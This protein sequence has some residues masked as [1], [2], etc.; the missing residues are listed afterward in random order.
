MAGDLARRRIRASRC[1]TFPSARPDPR[2]PPPRPR[3]APRRRYR[4]RGSDA[5]TVAV[6]DGGQAG[7]VARAVARARAAGADVT[8]LAATGHGAWTPDVSV[9]LQRP[10][11]GAPI[12]AALRGMS[13]RRV[14]VV[15]ETA[16]GRVA[17]PGSA[18][19]AAAGV[20]SVGG[21]DCGVGGP[22][23]RR[24]LAVPGVAAPGRRRGAPRVD[25]GGCRVG[26]GGARTRRPRGPLPRWDGVLVEALALAAP[27]RGRLAHA[28]GGRRHGSRALILAESRA[29]TDLF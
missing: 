2:K 23:G 6:V 24:A 4:R 5:P 1:A 22:A 28:P 20:R 9:A 3:P 25:Q 27:P 12:A 13:L 16:H 17:V 18:D 21:P 14:V 8:Q 10:A 11:V 15:A 26:T 7:V 19:V 29:S